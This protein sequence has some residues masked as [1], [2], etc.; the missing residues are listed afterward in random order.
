MKEPEQTKK[1]EQIKEPE[2]NKE[3][4]KMKEP[5][6][7]KVPVEIKKPEQ[8]KNCEK[9]DA[10]VDSVVEEIYG[11]VQTTTIT[12]DPAREM[13]ENSDKAESI[14]DQEEENRFNLL[15]EKVTQVPRPSL[16][17]YLKRANI[18]ASGSLQQLA[19][20]Y[21]SLSKD[22]R[23]QGFGKFAG[24][25]DEVL[26]ALESSS[27]GGIGPQLKTLLDKIVER[28]EL[29]RDEASNKTMI[30]LRDLDDPASQLTKD[31]RRILPLRF[32][33]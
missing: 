15:G 4:E 10:T 3:P 12:Q 20:L 22:A 8:I 1:P 19:G 14:E 32:T 2:K 25:S 28:N 7:N 5:E 9:N 13:Y 21:D 24:Y 6:K 30:V 11:I 33:R 27:E 23:K 18:P 31:L 26:L 16:S 17:N 29:T